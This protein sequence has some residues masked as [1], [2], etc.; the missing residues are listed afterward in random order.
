MDEKCENC[1]KLEKEF[2]VLET[3]YERLIDA[4]RDMIRGLI[5]VPY[6]LQRE[7]PELYEDLWD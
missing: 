6:E 2:K 5:N 3:E 1:K 4:T 7:F